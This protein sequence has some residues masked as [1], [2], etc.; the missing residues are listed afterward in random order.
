VK[1]LLVVDDEVGIT[2]ALN[3]IL[4]E[5]GFLVLVAP[6]GKV[7]LER[8]A[9]KR[10]DLILLD[11]MMPVMDGREMLQA[12][13]GGSAH[14]DIPVILMSALPRSSI[15]VDCKPAVFLRKPF[16]IDQLLA[17]IGRLLEGSPSR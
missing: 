15:A 3:D 7:A 11:Y 8:I 17:A 1:T 2:D 16:T 14:Q 4:S 13:R 12:L 6:N 9:E 10:P 5:E